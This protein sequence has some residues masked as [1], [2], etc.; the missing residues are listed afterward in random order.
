M[1]AHREVFCKCKHRDTNFTDKRE[2]QALLL[3]LF[4]LN[5]LAL[6]FLPLQLVA[7]LQGE[8]SHRAL[9]PTQWKFM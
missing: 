9:T 1:Q 4:P 5:N 8:C 7:N 6:R 3:E 2:G